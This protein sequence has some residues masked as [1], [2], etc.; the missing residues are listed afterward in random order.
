MLFVYKLLVNYIVSQIYIER[1][2]IV[3]HIANNFQFLLTCFQFLVGFCLVLVV[4][5]GGCFFFFFSSLLG[6]LKSNLGMF[7]MLFSNKASLFLHFVL[8]FPVYSL[9]GIILLY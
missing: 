9:K 1:A 3:D 6:D 4:L 8:V 2:I 5:V 7:K